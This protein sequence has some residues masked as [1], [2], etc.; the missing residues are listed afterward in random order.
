M[1]FWN[2]Y[3][4]TL[5][6]FELKKHLGSAKRLQNDNVL[7]TT[8]LKKH[9]IGSLGTTV[10]LNESIATCM[11]KKLFLSIFWKLWAFNNYH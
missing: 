5:L 10:N 6:L 4:I 1:K 2:C 3:I 11:I 9:L 8:Q 7:T